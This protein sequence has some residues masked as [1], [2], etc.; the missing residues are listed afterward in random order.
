MED[1]LR[2]IRNWASHG[3]LR[4]FYAELSAKAS[5]QGYITEL[6]GNTVTCY[7]VRKEGGILGLG[8]RTIKEPVLKAVQEGTEVV[9]PTESANAEFV[10]LLVGLLKQH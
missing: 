8:R 1:E 7:Q 5:Q 4:Q 2:K 10:H 6:E 9:I 3:T